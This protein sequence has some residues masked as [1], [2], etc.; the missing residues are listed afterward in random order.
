MGNLP[1]TLFGSSHALLEGT[2]F[3]TEA[4]QGASTPVW[5]KRHRRVV[6]VSGN[7]SVP[8]SHRPAGRFARPSAT[9]APPSK[10]NVVNL[11]K[12]VIG[13]AF[14][15]SVK[16]S[17]AATISRHASFYGGRLPPLRRVLRCSITGR[18]LKLMTLPQRGR[19]LLGTVHQ[20]DK[21]E[22]QS[23]SL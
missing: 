2:V 13:K 9:R 16:T 6:W 19:L 20:L 7:C 12:V 21:S 8:Y 1:G 5:R 14:I 15:T 23:S 17:V 10:S 18:F 22:F 11:A 3:D 4:S